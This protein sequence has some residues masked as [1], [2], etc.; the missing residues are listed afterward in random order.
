MAKDLDNYQRKI[1]E[2]EAANR[3]LQ[4]QL[5]DA[6]KAHQHTSRELQQ[7]QAE[8]QLKQLNE[9]LEQRVEARTRELK[10]SEARLQRLADNLPGLIFQFQ[11]EANGNRSFSYVSDGCRDIYELEPGD[12]L[13]CFDFVHRRDRD[14]LEQA[15]Q[16]SSLTLSGIHH[17]HRI[18]TPSGQLKWVQTIARPERRA[19]NSVL[20]DGLM[21]EISD[22]KRAE[23]DQQRLLSILEAT[24]DIVGIADAQG[25]SLYLN[26]AGQQLLEI[27]ETEV[28]GFPISKVHLPETLKQLKV[29]A[30]KAALK[31]GM[32]RG[33][34]SLRSLSGH[35]FPVSQVILAHRDKDGELEFLSTIIRDIS[36]LKQLESKR[37]RQEQALRAIV[38][39]TATQ[40][41]EAFFQTCVKHLALAL[42]V[43][44]A[45]LA[46]V[47]HEKEQKIA[48]TLAFW[49]GSDFGE[50]FQYNLAYTPCYNVADKNGICCYPNNVQKRFPKDQDLIK[51]EAESYVGIPIVNPDGHFFGLLTVL[52]TKPMV[53]DV[54]LQ[55]FILEIF[56]ARVGTEIERMQAEK[57]LLA[58][59]KELET[60]LTRLQKTQSQLVQSEKMSSLGQ[61]VAG[62]AH[63][64]NNPVSFIHGNLIHA[65]NYTQD[66]VRLIKSY[67]L[68]YPETPP[69]IQAVIDDIELEFLSQDLPNLFQSMEVGTE[70]IREIIKSLRTFSRL[71]ESDIK[72]VNLHDGIDSTL[73]ILQTRLR[74]QPWRPQIQV[75]KDY[76]DLPQIECYAGQLN[77][78]FMN[79]LSNAVDAI[80]ERDQQRTWQQMEQNPGKIQIRT[81]IIEQ[82]T[83]TMVEIEIIDNGPGI[84][85]KAMDHLFNP[86]FT[87][88][89]VGKGTG[90]GLSISYQ[91]IT[92]THGGTITYD[93]TLGQ[94]TTF[95]ITLPITQ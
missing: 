64:I 75:V 22:R 5:A 23:A 1:A 30:F 62:V 18:I 17:E 40:T 16:V 26:H 9:E 6:Q 61:M 53:Q 68:H 32:W 88:K 39:G 34:S 41:G 49:N 91:I 79:L 45:I 83:P 80:E 72:S 93:S 24:P 67:Q 35:Q 7:T 94:G 13:R 65:K 89:P 20:W 47:T 74:A 3:A 90:L 58:S 15:I 56:A 31:T 63:E 28:N 77:Q 92:E 38:Q 59:N 46:Q 21:I 78:V 42:N 81:R 71:D 50:N 82:L 69:D 51:L 70:R 4:T 54:E 86:F 19:D 29:T 73:T 25:N 37:D 84:S 2:L 11:V 12:F 85:S 55:A 10:S 27:P 48:T 8:N 43:R 87:T 14:A 52:D 76:G 60:L 44:Y 33:E 57:A 95:T 66:L 36:H